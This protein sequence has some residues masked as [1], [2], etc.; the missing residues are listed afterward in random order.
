MLAPL[1]VGLV[2]KARWDALADEVKAIAAQAANLG[3]VALL[4]L[5]IALN[6]EAVLRLIGTRGILAAVLFVVGSFIVG[7][8]LASRSRSARAVMGLGTAQRN[9]SA[10]MTIAAAN[11]AADPNVMVM[12]VVT[13]ILMLVILLGTGAELGKRGS[14]PSE[15][16]VGA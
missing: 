1:A 8:L 4:V 10:A 14:A 11:F 6:F 2:V 15:S 5:V 12:I 13:A 7:W 16:G 3:L 9:L